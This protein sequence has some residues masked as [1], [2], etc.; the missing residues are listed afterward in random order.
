M[1]HPSYGTSQAC[2]PPPQRTWATPTSAWEC[3]SSGGPS[4]APGLL[5]LCRNRGRRCRHRRRHSGVHGHTGRPMWLQPWGRNRCDG[6]WGCNPPT[7]SWRCRGCRGVGHRCTGWIGCP[8][9]RLS[10]RKPYE[11]NKQHADAKHDGCKPLA[12]L[13]K[14]AS[15]LNLR[16]MN[17][18]LTVYLRRRPCC[19]SSDDH[20]PRLPTTLG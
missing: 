12:S 18:S 19:E 9:T 15:F 13:H 6:G 5:W 17:E 4:G 2:N 10:R 16:V 1:V 3:P 11:C 7:R 8:N 14:N 20:L